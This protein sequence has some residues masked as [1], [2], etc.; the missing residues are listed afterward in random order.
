MKTTKRYYIYLAEKVI[1]LSETT[2]STKSQTREQLS[3]KFS[4]ELSKDGI[5]RLDTECDS[6]IARSKDIKGI[7]INEEAARKE[8]IIEKPKTRTNNIKES[9]SNQEESIEYKPLEHYEDPIKDYNLFEED[10]DEEYEEVNILDNEDEEDEEEINEDLK[11]DKMEPEEVK[12]PEI[13]DDD[14]Q[15]AVKNAGIS[16]EGVYNKDEIEKYKEK[17]SSKRDDVDFYFRKE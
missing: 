1:R 14:I 17:G 11:S 4:E 10:D 9:E 5:I 6:F 12:I 16:L 8:E 7:L 3:S 15:Q 2:E 13:T